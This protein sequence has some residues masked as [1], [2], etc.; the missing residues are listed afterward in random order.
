MRFGSVREGV[1]ASAKLRSATTSGWPAP[2]EMVTVLLAAGCTV[3]LTYLFNS[4]IS[5]SRWSSK[6][7]GWLPASTDNWEID[8]FSSASCLA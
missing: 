5:W 8:L 6:S 3:A 7:L 2:M 4:V 1:A